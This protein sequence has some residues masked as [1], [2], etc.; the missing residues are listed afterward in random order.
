MDPVIMCH[1]ALGNKNNFGSVGRALHEKTGRTVYSMDI[2]GFF[3]HFDIKRCLCRR[4]SHYHKNFRFRYKFPLVY[5]RCPHANASQWRNEQRL[6]NYEIFGESSM[7][8]Q[9][10]E[11]SIF[12][13]TSSSHFC[14]GYHHSQLHGY[15]VGQRRSWTSK[16]L[17]SIDGYR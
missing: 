2:S 3:L 1:G 14:N 4:G 10:A 7:E 16:R 8:V 12:S 5:S 17:H 15:S 13:W 11:I 6:V 9:K